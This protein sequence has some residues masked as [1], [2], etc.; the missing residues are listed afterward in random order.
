MERAFLVS[1]KIGRYKA[2]NTKKMGV[3]KQVT[4]TNTSHKQHRPHEQKKQKGKRVL[5]ALFVPR[6]ISRDRGDCRLDSCATNWSLKRH[7]VLNMCT[8]FDWLVIVQNKSIIC[9]QQGRKHRMSRT[10]A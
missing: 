10:V 7:G 8:S 5:T 6:E 3:I 1:H 2:E 9:I 4:Y